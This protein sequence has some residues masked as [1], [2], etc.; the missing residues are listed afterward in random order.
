M[1]KL[2]FYVAKT[3]ALQILKLGDFEEKS[4]QTI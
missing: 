4:V 2:E 1:R 3:N